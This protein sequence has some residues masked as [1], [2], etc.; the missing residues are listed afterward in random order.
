MDK[1]DIIDR[2]LKL[3][4]KP[5]DCALIIVLKEA[6]KGYTTI[7]FRKL[8]SDDE[9]KEYK[10]MLKAIENPPHGN[11]LIADFLTLIDRIDMVK[12]TSSLMEKYNITTRRSVGIKRIN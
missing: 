6:L 9:D 11:I 5:N 1:K 3:D 2:P 4:I 7:K 10:Q 8:F 12:N